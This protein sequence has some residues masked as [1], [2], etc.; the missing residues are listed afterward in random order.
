[1]TK[2]VSAKRTNSSRR[3]RLLADSFSLLSRF[4]MVVHA[5]RLDA[6]S[7]PTTVGTDTTTRAPRSRR[8]TRGVVMVTRLVGRGARTMGAGVLVVT[9]QWST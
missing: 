7:S 8:C 9:R 3:V 6:T 2:R 1:M 5:S 4:C